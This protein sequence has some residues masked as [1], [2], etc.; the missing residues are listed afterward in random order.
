MK[1]QRVNYFDNMFFS[2]FVQPILLI[3]VMLIKPFPSLIPF[4]Y[5]ILLMTYFEL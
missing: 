5:L 2:T 3:I 1:I 4:A